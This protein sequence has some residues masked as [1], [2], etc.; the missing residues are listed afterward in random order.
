MQGTFFLAVTIYTMI[1]TMLP[2]EIS[3]PVHGCQSIDLLLPLPTGAT[4]L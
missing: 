1:Y 4:R 3:M 2:I